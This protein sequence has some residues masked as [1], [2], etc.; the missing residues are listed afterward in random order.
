MQRCVSMRIRRSALRWGRAAGVGAVFC[1]LSATGA[2]AIYADGIASMLLHDQVRY[3]GGY[4]FYP[5]GPDKD[6]ELQEQNEALRRCIEE[7]EGVIS[8]NK[9]E[10]TDLEKQ[11]A[12][13]S[14]D[15]ERADLQKEIDELKGANRLAKESII[16][17]I[18]EGGP[19][20][21]WARDYW[22]GSSDGAVPPGISTGASHQAQSAGFQVSPASALVSAPDDGSG[23]ELISQVSGGAFYDDDQIDREGGFAGVSLGARTGI[24]PGTSAGAVFNFRHAESRSRILNSKLESDSFGFGLFLNT[25]LAEKVN[26]GLAFNYMHG[27]ANLRIGS[28]AFNRGTIT[29][30]FDTDAFSFSA[31]LSRRWWQTPWLWIEPAAS[32]TFTTMNRGSY[33]DSTGMRAGNETS[34]HGR[35]MVGGK[36]GHTF[37]KPRAS[38]D[39]AAALSHGQVYAG[40]KGIF[41]FVREDNQ[42]VA[43]AATNVYADTDA[44]G[45]KLF[46]G[47]NFSFSGGTNVSVAASYV[48]VGDYKAIQ[49]Q[50][51]LSVPLN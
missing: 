7:Y 39:D 40:V 10:I 25:S 50:A 6:A 34:E 22:T 43:V 1:A 37:F 51:R 36:A 49:G 4:D 5:S 21:H 32:V 8:K 27:D 14:S 18:I 47:A 3:G 23:V 24:A 35:L 13:A 41:D 9:L 11:L 16:R 17:L 46:G 28:S 44:L 33:T 20:D 38:G 26:L 12:Q 29:A 15:A 2:Q 19:S 42:L 45:A 48:F 30:N 31:Q